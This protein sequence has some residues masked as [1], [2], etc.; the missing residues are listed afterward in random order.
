MCLRSGKPNLNR[1]GARVRFP[2]NGEVNDSPHALKPPLGPLP[3]SPGTF[4][5]ALVV[6]ETQFNLAI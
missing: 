1:A 2:G 3:A 6:A 4:H 5:E